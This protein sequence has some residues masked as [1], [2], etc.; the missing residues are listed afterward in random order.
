MYVYDNK[1]K[2]GAAIVF[3]HGA[4]SSHFMWQ[5]HVEALNEYHCIVPDLPGHGKSNYEYWT[6]LEETTEKV[7]EVIRNSGHKKVNVVGLSLGGSIIFQLLSRHPEFIESA[8]IDG[9][10]IIPIKNKNL[11]KLGVSI[12]SRFLKL[13]PV[14]NIMAGALGITSISERKKFEEDLRDVDPK[15]FRTAFAQA[16][17][18]VEPM[19]F[20]DAKVPTLFVCGEKEPLEIHQ[21]N[22][23][24]SQSI[25]G[26]QAFMAPSLNHGWLAKNPDLHIRMVKMWI[27][28]HKVAEGLV[29][30]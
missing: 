29:S 13:K 27:E 1:N 28:E 5:K 10:G 23:K 2:K 11:I 20:T 22:R 17:D 3:L 9:A 24:Y 16:N 7:F 4:A 14:I 21:S 8:I 25:P 26:S 12:V 19:G 15:S 6:T 18:Q 30:E